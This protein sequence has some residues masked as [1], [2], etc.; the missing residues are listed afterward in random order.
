MTMMNEVSE[1]VIEAADVMLLPLP[2][3][4]LSRRAFEQVREEMARHGRHPPVL[5]VL[6]M[7]DAR[8]RLHR[9]AR[10][11]F[12]AGWPVI[13]ASSWVEQAAERRAPIATFANWSEAS[14]GLG[15]VWSAVEMKLYELDR[16]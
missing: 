15:R 2:P 1:Q 10:E 14:R 9:E 16:R 8:R 12:A 4:P 7:Y 3:S 6:S 13:P 5:P 11:T